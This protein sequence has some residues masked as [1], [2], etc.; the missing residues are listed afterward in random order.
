MV[1]VCYTNREEFQATPL[2]G[3]D[4]SRVFLATQHAIRKC[5]GSALFEWY[6]QLCM[7]C[8]PLALVRP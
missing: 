4:T 2:L 1:A 6:H 3:P 8:M 5:L 7:E